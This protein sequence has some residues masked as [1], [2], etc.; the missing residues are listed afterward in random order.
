MTTRSDL[1]DAATGV[2]GTK[3]SGTY[4]Q[5]LKPL[6]GFVKWNGR[7]AGD[8]GHGWLD[9]WQIWLA[10]HQ[11]VVTA[12]AWIADHLQ[13]LIDALDVELVVTS[14]V[15][16]EL[17]LGTTSVNGLIIEGSREAGD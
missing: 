14:A 7:R 2:A 13:D 3:V 11:D 9:D 6:D 12:E 17:V 4:R 16:A 10:L 1:A 5:S 8:N 15:P